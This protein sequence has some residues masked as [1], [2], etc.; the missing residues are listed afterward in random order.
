[1]LQNQTRPSDSNAKVLK[2]SYLTAPAD[3]S[4]IPSRLAIV[5]GSPAIAADDLRNLVRGVAKGGRRSWY[6]TSQ[7]SSLSLC[8]VE[9]PAGT[10][11]T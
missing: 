7:D 3:M 5:T 10:G 1:M 2:M 4:I 8:E 9:T 6:G 11:F